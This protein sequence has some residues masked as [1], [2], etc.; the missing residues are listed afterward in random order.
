MNPRFARLHAWGPADRRGWRKCRKCGAEW[1]PPDVPW[2]PSVWRWPLS[3]LASYVAVPCSGRQAVSA[4]SDR[5]RALLAAAT[6]GDEND[7]L[8]KAL[9]G[10]RLVKHGELC[11][12]PPPDMGERGPS[13]ECDCGA[14]EHNARIDAALRGE[15]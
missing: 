2:K 14:D 9:E 7:R 3:G 13:D 10:A 4:A 8:R 5:A 6:P 12:V 1:S 11:D 15:G